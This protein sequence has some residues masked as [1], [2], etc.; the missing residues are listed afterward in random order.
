MKKIL[1]TYYILSSSGTPLTGEK[2]NEE[3]LQVGYPET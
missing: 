1:I 3:T 2:W